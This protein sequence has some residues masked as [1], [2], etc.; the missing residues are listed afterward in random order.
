MSN[1]SCRLLVIEGYGLVTI[2]KNTRRTQPIEMATEQNTE[3]SN[4]HRNSP[5][6]CQ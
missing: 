5:P 6:A 3:R 2:E 1:L 4:E